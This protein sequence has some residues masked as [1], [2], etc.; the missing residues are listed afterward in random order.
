MNLNFGGKW[1]STCCGEKNDSFVV[2]GSL[3]GIIID[4]YPIGASDKS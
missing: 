3:E 4:D 2:I 1:F